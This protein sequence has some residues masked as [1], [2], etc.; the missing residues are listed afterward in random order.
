MWGP[1]FMVVRCSFFKLKGLCSIGLLFF[2][3]FLLPFSES[4]VSVLCVL[5]SVQWGEFCEVWGVRNG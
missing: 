1:D 4:F 5:C 3:F 2:S